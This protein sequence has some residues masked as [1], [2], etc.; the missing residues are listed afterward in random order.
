MEE[1]TAMALNHVNPWIRYIEERIPLPTLS[2]LI[3]GMVLSASQI[4]TGQFFWKSTVIPFLSVLAFSVLLHTIQDYK[5]IDKDIVV[6]PNRP[7]ARGLFSGSE[8]ERAITL[9]IAALLVIAGL[10]GLLLGS[11]CG[12]IYGV[13][14]LYSWFIYKE[15]FIGNWLK[16]HPLL[17]AATHQ[18]VIL[19]IAAYL[20]SAF[21]PEQIF[22]QATLG[23][24]L[25]LLGGFFAYEIGR[26]SDPN[27]HPV[28][29]TY[30]HVYG[31]QVCA[32]L[33]AGS[34][35]AA[36]IGSFYAGVHIFLWSLQFTVIVA[37]IGLATALS[38]RYRNIERVATIAL[39]V[40]CWSGA[41]QALFV[42]VGG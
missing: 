33:I 22:D 27:A 16:Q 7:F 32:G 15:F 28:L 31:H 6:H 42:T 4:A 30:L 5:G 3:L 38:D 9:G 1:R 25:V 20:I 18:V 8:I 40:H 21:A 12:L 34:M 37:C 19:A 24:G 23:Y 41:I 11:K 10:N 35:V 29:R 26:M 2:F 14:V 13:I 17:Y 36:A 39:V